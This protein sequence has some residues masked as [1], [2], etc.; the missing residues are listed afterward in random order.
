MSVRANSEGFSVEN[1]PAN[2]EGTRLMFEGV[3]DWLAGFARESEWFAK[4]AQPPFAA[5][6]TTFTDARFVIE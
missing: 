3:P 6:V 2:S 5:N 1:E 4:I